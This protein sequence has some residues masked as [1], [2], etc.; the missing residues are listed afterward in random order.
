[1]A[2]FNTKDKR[3]AVQGPVTSEQKPSGTT[4]EGG[5]GFQRDARGELF[6]LAVTYFAGEDTFYEGKDARDQR[7][8]DL[9]RQVA[10]QDPQ[11]FGKFLPWLR[12]EGFMR[13]GPIVA[14]AEGVQAMVAAKIPGGRQLVA[15]VLARAD[16]P[17]E[18]V[19]YLGAKLPK[20]LKRGL[21]DAVLRL[22]NEYSLLK[23]DTASSGVRFGDVIELVHPDAKTPGQ[24]ALFTHAIDRRHGRTS[25]MEVLAKLPKIVAQSALR[26]QV[27]SGAVEALASTEQLRDAG[28]TWEDTLSLAGSKVD[29]AKLW[30]A[31]IPTMGYMALLRN[32]RN[33]DDA[34]ISKQ[35]QRLVED[36]LTDPAQVV[37]SK[38]FPYRFLAAYEQ[39][40]S[41]R[42]GHV[43]EDAL[44][45]SVANVPTM[46]GRT[47]VLVD[48]S[49]SMTNRGFSAKSTMTPAKAA[50]IFGVAL[51]MKGGT[52]LYG[53]A[54]GQFLFTPGPSLLK[55]I[56][57]FVGCTG[58]VGHGTDVGGAIRK[59]FKP[60]T[61]DRVVIISDMQT[62]SGGTGYHQGVGSLV[63]ANVPIYS[64]NLGGY[65]NT[66]M[67]LG[68]NR[69]EFGSLSDSA[70]KMMA[71]LEARKDGKWPWDE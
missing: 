19:A 40:Q 65:R 12:N 28:M 60:G 26:Q 6:L 51:A 64:Y 8:K 49:A 43:L 7:F 20:P 48:T 68:P 71:W 23:Y 54:D 55:S 62:I 4:Y 57:D 27:A 16:E 59:T 45:A 53:F 46:R 47:L 69:H 50:A 9:V 11:W 39:V 24:D 25:T 36:R 35:A 10:V 70:F 2:K 42:W 38:Q 34:K 44:T 22:Y 13:S 3:R 30:E 5:A 21:A 63:P 37:K 18:L 66:A 56:G 14:L 15:Q 32:L 17:G 61:H 58:K 31:Q 1:M 33:F 67:A 29:K 52:D 41:L